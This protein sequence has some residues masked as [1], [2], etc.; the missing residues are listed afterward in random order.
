MS[1]ILLIVVIFIVL[2]ASYLVIR[3]AK[4]SYKILPVQEE[5]A[6]F[7][8]ETTQLQD[9]H[10]FTAPGEK[11]KVL[12]PVLPQ[13]VTQNVNDPRTQEVR[14]YDMYVSEK[15][16]LT[17]FMISLITYPEVDTESEIDQVLS[18]VFNDMMAS[19]P[20]NQ[21]LS[22]KKGQYENYPAIDFSLG[23]DEFHIDTKSFL[24]NRVLYVLTSVAK[25]E[26]Y[27]PKEY[28]FFI[29]SFEITTESRINTFS[30]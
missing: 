11:F 20:N 27:N 6:A 15:A 21:I 23:N 29:N 13:H 17:I 12:L 4:E 7:D 16:N 30:R 25:N 22:M 19:N 10:E 2:L 3:Y 14:K 26:N 5:E 9:W 24:A 8:E 1:R 18:N 28:M